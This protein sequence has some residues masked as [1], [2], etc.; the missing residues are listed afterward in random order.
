[1]TFSSLLHTCLV[2]FMPY[3][4]GMATLSRALFSS[5][6]HMMRWGRALDCWQSPF[7]ALARLLR[8]KQESNIET[9]PLEFPNRIHA[10]HTP[11]GATHQAARK[12]LPHTY[13]SCS[14][15]LCHFSPKL[16]HISAVQKVR[17]ESQHEIGS[18][19]FTK[20]ELLD[21]R[22][23]CIMTHEQVKTELLKVT[24]VVCSLVW[25]C[26]IFWLLLRNPELG[27][28][29]KSPSE[30]RTP[31]VLWGYRH[32]LTETPTSTLDLSC[33]WCELQDSF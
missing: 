18:S 8:W 26:N 22:R 14:R 4:K 20:C 24:R 23:V 11:Q 21:A 3:K 32:R 25:L 30:S 28:S 29:S 2:D 31:L 13:G 33:A 10:V 5:S 9:L 6:F 27:P 1:M 16:L 7:R 12:A 17:T 19:T 15:P